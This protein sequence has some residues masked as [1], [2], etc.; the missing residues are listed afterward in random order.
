MNNKS[1]LLLKCKWS[2]HS[3][4]DTN[5]ASFTQSLRAKYCITSSSLCY[6]VP[7]CQ[8][9]LW[10]RWQLRYE[11]TNNKSNHTDKISENMSKRFRDYGK[12]LTRMMQEHS[13]K[14]LCLSD[15]LPPWIA[16]SLWCPRR[17][18][19]W[20]SGGG[21]NQILGYPNNKFLM[22]T[23]WIIRKTTL[24]R[25]KQML[26]VDTRVRKQQRIPGR[27]LCEYDRTTAS[28]PFSNKIFLLYFNVTK[29]E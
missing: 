16:R 27:G 12:I 6:P 21:K 22:E 24:M 17:L 28:P 1:A 4:R 11:Q 8:W 3:E 15:W 2:A 10:R 19:A 14:S 26:Y 13:L 29:L 18:V 20:G 23:T 7:A 5:K 9:E 25:Q